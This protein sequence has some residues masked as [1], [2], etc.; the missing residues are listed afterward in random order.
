MDHLE[1][2]PQHAALLVQQQRS[3]EDQFREFHPKADDLPPA[4]AAERV[5]VRAVGGIDERIEDGGVHAPPAHFQSGPAVHVVNQFDTGMR[6]LGHVPLLAALAEAL[7][8]A[9]DGAA[10]ADDLTAF[11]NIHKFSPSVSASPLL[12]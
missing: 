1:Q 12:S 8:I 3:F 5:E 11:L 2:F 10:V 6:V 9:Q 7:A 4:L